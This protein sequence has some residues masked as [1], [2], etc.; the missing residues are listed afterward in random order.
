M[1]KE[2]IL[3][4]IKFTYSGILE[5]QI[6]YQSIKDFWDSKGFDYLEKKHEEKISEDGSRDI[7]LEWNC[8][9]KVTDYCKY[10]YEFKVNIKGMKPVMIK[11]KEFFH[12]NE[13]KVELNA[14]LEVDYDKF[15]GD[16]PFNIFLRALYEKYI[17]SGEIKEHKKKVRTIGEEFLNM[18][19]DL[20][21]SFKV[22]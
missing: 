17:I 21:A 9:K 13:F 20:T 2:R 3:D 19:K 1:P 18:L 4:G 12:V 16:K 22:L 8:E 7:T 11:G 5:F 6:I 15:F 14:D 10:V